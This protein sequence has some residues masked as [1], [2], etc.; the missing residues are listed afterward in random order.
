MSI[1]KILFLVFV[2]INSSQYNC[3]TNVKW[4]TIFPNVQ[5]L[6]YVF[7][8]MIFVQSTEKYGIINHPG[9]APLGEVQGGRPVRPLGT[10]EQGWHVLPATVLDVRRCSQG[11]HWILPTVLPL[12]V[13]LQ[14]LVNPFQVKLHHCQPWPPP[15]GDRVPALGPHTVLVGLLH[16]APSDQCFAAWWS[17]SALSPV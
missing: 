13:Q 6:K 7:F 1:S 15:P 16:H 10:L 5:N 3:F 17:R 12:T 2:A 9:Q 11:N 4:I 14:S 8:Q